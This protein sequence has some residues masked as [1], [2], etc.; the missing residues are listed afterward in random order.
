M[1]GLLM[2]CHYF[3]R[4]PGRGAAG[5]AWREE[6]PD[7]VEAVAQPSVACVI[8]RDVEREAIIDALIDELR[9][10]LGGIGSSAAGSRSTA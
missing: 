2:S 7:L 6:R 10:L 3:C 5:V 1:T 4:R 8:S 9:P